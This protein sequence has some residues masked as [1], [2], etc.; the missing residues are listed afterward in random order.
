MR[1]K[2]MVL[3]SRGEKYMQIS[4]VAAKKIFDNGVK[5]YLLQ[6][7][8]RFDN[9]WEGI[10]EVRKDSDDW[11][12]SEKQFERIINSYTY[13]NCDKERKVCAVFQKI[14]GVKYEL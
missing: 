10:C 12:S 3:E 13:Y 11:M 2:G 4:K 9:P 7:N 5:V 6:S 8:M 14:G 1:Y